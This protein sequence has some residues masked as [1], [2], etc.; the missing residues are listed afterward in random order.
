MQVTVTR[1][2]V[3]DLWDRGVECFMPDGHQLPVDTRLEAPCSLKWIESQYRLR[4]GA[5]SY[6]VSGYLFD[7]AMGRY[8][9]IGEQVQM[10][11]GDHP[12]G[13]LSTSPAFYIGEGFMSVGA[14]TPELVEFNRFRPDLSTF[15]SLPGARTIHI[16]HDVWIGHGAFIRPGVRIGTG[17]V[18]A[19]CAVVTKDVPPYAIVGG[20]PA[21]VIR[22][23]FSDGLRERLHATQWW[24]RAPWQ[25][26]GI[27]LSRPAESVSA[28]EDRIAETEPFRAMEIDL[29]DW[30]A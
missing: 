21:K 2:L 3:K 9:S 4:I 25:L 6:C 1:A 18:V 11:R 30:A 19:A 10:G 14:S 12:M 22:Y 15:A 23:R 27:D 16:E 26:Q 5:F 29:A 20:N 7:V 28:L 13:W 24:T 8:T 17:A